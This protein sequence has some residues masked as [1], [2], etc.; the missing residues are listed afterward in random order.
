MN[1]TFTIVDKNNNIQKNATAI[2]KFSL[3]NKDYLI[4][5][6]DENE[7]NRQVFVSRLI[8]NSEGKYFI[9][10]ILP[11][12]KSKLSDIVYNIL[13]LTPTNYKKGENPDTLLNS[14]IEKFKI[15][16]LSINNNSIKNILFEVVDENLLN[17]TNGI[18][19]GMSGSPIVQNGKLVGAVTH[20][21]LDNPAKGYGILIENMLKETD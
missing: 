5:C 18:V 8:L 10:N 7:E 2:I 1:R 12:E 14:L 3:E 13:I 4:Y 6:I 11:E 17:K 9:E 16:I 19:Q 20:V 15:N 21:V